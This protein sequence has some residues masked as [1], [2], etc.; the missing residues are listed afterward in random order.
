MSK[1]K[2]WGEVRKELD[3][4][5]EEEEEIRI[6]TEIIQATIEAREK[7]K[8]TQTELSKITGLKQSVIARVEKGVHSPCISTLVKILT[9]IGYTIKVVPLKNHKAVSSVSGRKV[10]NK[11]K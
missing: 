1:F 6:E 5:P 9:P 2:T 11:K 10:N 7:S 3:F 8:V 4:T